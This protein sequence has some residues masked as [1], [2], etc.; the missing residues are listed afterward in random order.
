[1]FR[2]S[3]VEKNEMNILCPAHFST[4]LTAFEMVREEKAN[5]GQ[6]GNDENIFSTLIIELEPT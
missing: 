1:M 4:S 5:G 2:T 3:F 6:G